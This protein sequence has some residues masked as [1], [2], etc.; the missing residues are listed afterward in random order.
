MSNAT[1]A[2]DERAAGRVRWPAAGG[3]I[4][5]AAATPAAVGVARGV[6]PGW[7]LALLAL[8]PLAA[9]VTVRCF[10]THRGRT[11][12]SGH[13]EALRQQRHL[14]DALTGQSAEALLVISPAGR[15]TYANPPAANLFGFDPARAPVSA[16]VEQLHPDERQ[17]TV[18]ALH[19]RL[20]HGDGR[21]IRLPA[22]L[23]DQ[24][25]VARYV[26][27]TAVD[28]RHDAQIGGVTLAVRETTERSKLEAQL[29]QLAFHDPLTHL[30]NRSLFQDRLTQ[31]RG[32]ATR[33]GRP[34]A[35]LL[36]D[37]DDFKEVNDT[38][39]HPVGDQLLE[40]LA[41]RLT[42]TLRATDTI[43]RLGGDE[44]VVLCEDLSAT[45]DALVTA[46]RLLAVTDEPFDLDGH[47]VGL[48]MSIGIAVD[49]GERTADELVR[50]ADIALYEAKAEGK[51]RWSLHRTVMTTRIQQRRELA[52]EL[53][54]AIADGGIDVA[55]QP[56]VRLADERMVGVEALARWTDDHGQ[57][58]APTEFIPLAERDGLIAD[59]G[60]RVLERALATIS[61]I[62]GSHGDNPLSVGINVSACQLR[63]PRLVDR[64]RELAATHTLRPRTLVLELTESVLLDDPMQAL[65]LMRALQGLGV[66]FAI[67][68]FGTG[69]SSLSY[70]RQLPVDIIKIDRSFV[71]AML[72]DPGQRDLVEAIVH[73]GRSLHLD[74]VAEGVEQTA[75]R[76]ELKAIGCEYAQGFLWSAPL[77]A[78]DL[79]ARL[80]EDRTVGEP[81]APLRTVGGGAR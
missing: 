44:F 59:L 49:H 12:P 30:P 55:Y 62:D 75:Q 9:A 56:I 6:D 53:A 13:A 43:A 27:L 71:S 54:R 79:R 69:Y 29:R 31:A 7:I 68:D 32:R 63:D 60:D 34:L 16:L 64:V 72:D 23:T 19:E 57:P 11:H 35:V 20:E 74:V 17:A 77:T 65:G 40:R 18:A 36:C 61:T 26:E 25:G 38:L 42:A 66:R 46:R 81:P 50:D 37:L 28:Q 41:E 73:L 5:L 3:G 52:G 80:L 76:D 4:M 21:P 58:R 78:T 39:G 10:A 15:V 47:H 14:L 8:L 48:G 22:R 45:R 51:Q 24:D 2:A 1:G 33:S 67:D 70:L